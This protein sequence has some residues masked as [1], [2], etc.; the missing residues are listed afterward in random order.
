L[1]QE[2]DNS[3]VEDKYK[4]VISGRIDAGF[5]QLF[6][7]LTVELNPITIL[8]GLHNNFTEVL[9]IRSLKELKKQREFDLEHNLLTIKCL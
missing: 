1:S 4:I 7:P 8:W 2:E 9:P 6:M 3:R 5:R